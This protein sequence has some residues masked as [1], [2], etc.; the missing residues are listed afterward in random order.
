[1]SVDEFDF[2]TH[3][4]K[5]VAVIRERCPRCVYGAWDNYGI[6]CSYLAHKGYKGGY[7]SEWAARCEDFKD[8]GGVGRITTTTGITRSTE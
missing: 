3:R 7:G 2:A 1:M 5:A 4:K 8:S 6:V